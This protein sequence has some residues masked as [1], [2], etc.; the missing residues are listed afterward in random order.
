MKVEVRINDKARG[1]G[2]SMSE[3]FLT[4]VEED[5]VL[6]TG[7]LPIEEALSSPLRIFC[8]KN[9][10]DAGERD[11]TFDAFRDQVNTFLMEKFPEAFPLP[12][13]ITLGVNPHHWNRTLGMSVDLDE[14][15][16][17]KVYKEIRKSLAPLAQYIAC[18]E[19]SGDI[20]QDAL[21]KFG[22]RKDRGKEVKDIGY[23]YGEIQNIRRW[24]FCNCIDALISSGFYGRQG[25]AEVSEEV[26]IDVLKLTAKH[27][28]QYFH[29]YDSVTGA[30]AILKRLQQKGAEKR[31]KKEEH[32]VKAQ[33]LIRILKVT[34][35]LKKT[36]DKK[37]KQTVNT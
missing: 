25:D 5:G 11:S 1:C 12:E 29:G 33:E 9:F 35:R 7:M 32:R 4:L 14:I 34:V 28:P 10:D 20:P 19:L 21:R 37:V 23:T 8:P 24:L 2:S 27:Q 36:A 13:G 15:P 22:L 6:K 31:L 16:S 3:T 18:E 26:L 30:E 17:I